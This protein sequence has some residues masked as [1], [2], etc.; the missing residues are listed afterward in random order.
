MALDS[1]L[2]KI[3]SDIVWHEQCL[4]KLKEDKVKFQDLQ[5]RYPN[6]FQ[7]HGYLCMDDNWGKISNLK[8]KKASNYFSHSI[9]ANFHVGRKDFIDGLKIYSY[10]LNNKIAEINYS[11]NN[12]TK[13]G[14]GII[15]IFNYKDMIGNQC[16]SKS[17]FILR[18]KKYLVSLIVANN[19]VISSDSYDTNINKLILLK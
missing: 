19:L 7:H 17:K 15:T 3:D 1:V 11:Y 12:T 13:R 10:P 8:L 5:Q 9:M 6:M 14:T 4:I 18:I 16:P 2:E